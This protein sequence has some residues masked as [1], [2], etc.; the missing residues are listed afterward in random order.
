MATEYALCA[1]KH[2]AHCCSMAVLVG[3]EMHLW[4]KLSGSREK[5]K[6]FLLDTPV[7]PS[8]LFINA[9]N[10]VVNRFQAAKNQSVAFRQFL[11]HQS[12]NP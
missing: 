9:V 10:T 12:Q 1:T 8:G 7:L 3:M 2:M 4:L 6:S 11:P 5:E